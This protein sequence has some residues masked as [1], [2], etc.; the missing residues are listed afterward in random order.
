MSRLTQ[1]LP[2]TA[3]VLV[4]DATGAYRVVAHNDLACQVAQVKRF[5]QT[6]AQDRGQLSMLRDLFYDAQY[7]MPSR[8]RVLV[9][10]VTYSVVE[11]SHYDPPPYRG[12]QWFRQVVIER[13]G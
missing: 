4:A 3:R 7:K 6:V 10:D 11:G 8:A 12:K 5:A 2:Q 13:A 9:D 1:L